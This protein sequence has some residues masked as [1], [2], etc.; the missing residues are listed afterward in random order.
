MRSQ[1]TWQFTRFNLRWKG[2]A[3]Y[4]GSFDNDKFDPEMLKQKDDRYESR[5]NRM[6]MS[7][8]FLLS[9]VDERVFKSLSLH[10]G[11]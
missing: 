7:H 4:T 2:T 11:K 10:R 8:S 3:D 1:Y 6:S 9:P 5:Y